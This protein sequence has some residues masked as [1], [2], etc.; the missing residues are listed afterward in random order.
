MDAQSAAALSTVAAGISAMAAVVTAVIAVR[1]LAGTREDSRD[2]TRPVLT[3]EL[4]RSPLTHGTIDLVLSNYGRTSARN[5]RVAFDPPIPKPENLPESDMQHWIGL[6]YAKP[7]VQ[8]PPSMTLSN[9]YRA[10]PDNVHP[11]TVT[12]RYEGQDRRKYE[13]GFYLDP[14]ILM[15]ETE[16]TP[17]DSTPAEKRVAKALEVIARTFDRRS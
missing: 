7:L 12:I 3:A 9:V 14:D 15:K 6:R 17:S 13:D 11:V 10:G 4:K 5:V 8:W 2:R 1:S 16:A